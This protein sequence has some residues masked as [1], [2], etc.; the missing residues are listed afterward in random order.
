M[1]AIIYTVG[2]FTRDGRQLGKDDLTYDQAMSLA[3]VYASRG[4]VAEIFGWER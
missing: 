4:L 2:A 3:N 1:T